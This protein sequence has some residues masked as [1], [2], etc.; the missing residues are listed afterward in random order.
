MSENKKILI[1]EMIKKE[2]SLEFLVNNLDMSPLEIM[3][4]VAELKNDGHNVSITKKNG[5][6]FLT[7]FGDRKLENDTYK[8]NKDSNVIRL[9]LVSDTRFGSKYQQLSLLNEFYNDAY[10]FEADMVIHLGDI[11]EGVYKG[12]KAIYNDSLFLHG[13]EEQADYIIK[14]YPHIEGITTYFITGEHDLTH[15]SKQNP[16]YI[17]KSISEK[18]EDMVYLGSNQC[19]LEINNVKIYLEHMTSKRDQPLQLSYRPQETIRTI[20]SE[21]KFDL[22]FQG[23]NLYAQTFTQRNI[24]CITVPSMVA[25]TP[26]IRSKSLYNTV[27]AW[28]VELDLNDDGKLENTY[29]RFSPNYKTIENDYKFARVLKKG[30]K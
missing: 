29:L 18:R 13:M 24:R 5:E 9:G 14:S 3:G 28:L 1:K 25:T 7:D 16:K 23:H 26:E 15:V 8:I 10:D 30:D 11:S 2:Q 20:R 19:N 6:V 27:G 21:D 4:I 12:A 17:G 22:F